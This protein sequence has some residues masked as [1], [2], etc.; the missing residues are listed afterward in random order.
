[1][2]NKGLYWIALGVV[3]LGLNSEYQ[4]G[5]LSLANQ[6]ADRAQAVYCQVAT[7]AEQTWALAKLLTSD[8]DATV[9]DQFLAGQQAE[10]DRVMADRQADVDRVI[11]EHQAGLDRAMDLRQADLDRVQQS[12]DRMHVVL[13]R[14]QVEKLRKFELVRFKVVNAATRRIVVCPQTGKRVIIEAAPDAADVSV[15]VDEAQ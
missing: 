13:D 14:V 5:R 8:Q 15:N 3:V 6:L 11:A 9:A 10:I 1:M 12:L 2:N 4:R 7:G